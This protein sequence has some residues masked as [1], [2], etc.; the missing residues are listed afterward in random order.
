MASSKCA[1]IDNV[2]STDPS[3][4]ESWKVLETVFLKTRKTKLTRGNGHAK[5]RLETQPKKRDEVQQDEQHRTRREDYPRIPRMRRGDGSKSTPVTTSLL[6]PLVLNQR[7][8]SEGNLLAAQTFDLKNHREVTVVQNDKRTLRL[9]KLH[10]DTSPRSSLHMDTSP[11]L[12][13]KTVSKPVMDVPRETLRPLVINNNERRRI[14][15]MHIEQEEN[16][17]EVDDA[18]RESLLRWLSEQ[19]VSTR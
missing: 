4:Y 1:I 12:K 17:Y 18:K 14:L 2:C 16:S 8:R 3:K 5:K 9:P 13:K 19:N 7:S 15:K 6:K 11:E 10:Q